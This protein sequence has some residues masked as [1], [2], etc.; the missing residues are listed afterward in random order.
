DFP[1]WDVLR[2]KN[3]FGEGAHFHPTASASSLAALR[4][5]A[6]A[7]PLG[8]I[9]CE[10]PSNPLLRCA[11][12][13]GITNLLAGSDVPLIVDDTVASSANISLAAH[14]DAITTSLTKCFSGVG[15][16]MGGSVMLN[17][18]SP[19]YPALKSAMDAVYEPDL[20]WWEDAIVL[21]R[22][23][24][25]YAERV[26]R[27][28]SSAELLAE[29]LRSHPAV[30]SIFYPKWETPEAYAEVRLE[31][32]GY[33][34]LFSIV[35][36]EPE[37]HTAKFFDALRVTKGPSLGTNYTLACPYTLLAH[38]PELDWA[39]SCGVSRWLVRVS[40]GLEDPGDLIERFDEAL[41]SS[42]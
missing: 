32:G 17:A 27:M 35:L 22:N 11:D 24:R 28:S 30:E 19:C 14:A 15:D 2:V 21:E 33:G 40:V 41:A 23:S 20:L 31:G 29:H 9:L 7:E 12:I 26:A 3:E 39:E 36:K 37:H 6:S 5:L 25:D 16:V 42:A 34:A 8:G 10:M 13:R 1:Y 4:E 38:Y 18:A